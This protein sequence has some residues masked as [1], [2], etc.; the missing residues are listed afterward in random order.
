MGYKRV[1]LFAAIALPFALTS[2][3]GNSVLAEEFA[4]QA[5]DSKTVTV[6]TYESAKV[7]VSNT[8]YATSGNTTG[9]YSFQCEIEVGDQGITLSSSSNEDDVASVNVVVD[10]KQ[11]AGALESIYGA[12][13]GA[14]SVDLSYEYKVSSKFVFSAS[15]SETTADGDVTKDNTLT[16][17]DYGMLTRKQVFDTLVKNDGSNVVTAQSIE[18][19]YK[20]K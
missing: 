11:C 20:K 3:S 19:S 4:K 1:G 9:K 5:E 17:N 8:V 6:D 14:T 2:C 18:I 15:V 13:D 10:L 16:W 7:T 12:D